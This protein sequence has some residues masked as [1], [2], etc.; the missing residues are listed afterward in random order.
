M[1]GMRPVVLFGRMLNRRP[2][3]GK[4]TFRR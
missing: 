3:V 1:K 4:K 2:L